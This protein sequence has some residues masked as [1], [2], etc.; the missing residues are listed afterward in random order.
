MITGSYINPGL[1]QTTFP[2]AGGYGGAGGSPIANTAG[3]VPQTI[4]GSL[5]LLQ[6]PFVIFL[7]MFA[8]L[9]LLK[10]FGESPRSDINPEHVHVGGYNWFTVGVI[11]VTFISVWKLAFTRWPVPGL[12]QLFNFV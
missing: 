5:G 7:G 12:S 2:I 10:I 4:L 9:G 1:G 3:A 11:A 8:L 6:Q